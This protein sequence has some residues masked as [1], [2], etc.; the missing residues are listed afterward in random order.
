MRFSSIDLRQLVTTLVLVVVSG[1]AK[2]SGDD[3]QVNCPSVNQDQTG[4]F[5]A[6][7]TGLPL[8]ISADATF[9]ADE[10]AALQQAMQAWN[11]FGQ[12]IIGS[13]IF[14]LNTADFD[15]STR[16]LDPHVCSQNYGDA[17]HVVLIRE[18]SQAHWSQI[19]LSVNVPGATIRCSSN[20]VVT[21]QMTVINTALAQ[22]STLPQI[23]THELG[24]AIG[25]D[26]SCNG[27]SDTST[28]DFISCAGVAQDD[29]YHQAVMFPWIQP[30]YD[31][32]PLLRQ[33]DQLRGACMIQS[34]MP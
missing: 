32:S 17:G 6:K 27:A 9:N 20:G 2:Q 25:L 24:H 8:T 5:M 19:G 10:Q 16:A 18:S 28:A 34:T 14:E 3:P 30:Q 31:A 23:F 33:N 15:A 13:D 12:S 22:A 29:P 11:E 21:E 7:V 4:S 1:C 26:H